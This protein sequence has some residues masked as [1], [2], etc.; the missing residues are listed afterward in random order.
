MNNKLF[1][2]Q[3]AA[4]I[5][6][7]STKTLRRWDKSGRFVP[8]RT[9][10]N[11]RRYAK[12]QIDGFVR[13]NSLSPKTNLP[14]VL[15]ELPSNTVFKNHFLLNS[16]VYPVMPKLLKSHEIMAESDQTASRELK[17]SSFK[18][19][20]ILVS[21]ILLT[22][23]TGLAVLAGYNLTPNFSEKK[24]Q[25]VKFISNLPPLRP[26][27]RD[28]GGQAQISLAPQNGGQAV[29]AAS[30][31]S[32]NL[33][34]NVNVPSV[35]SDTANFLTTIGIG[36]DTSDA[37]ALLD[38]T[39]EDKGFLAPR[40][41]TAQ[42]D[43]IASPATGLFVYN[44][45]TNQ[46]NMYDGTIWKNISG[47]A[48][49]DV[50]TGD[51][52][53]EAGAQGNSF[54]FHG[55][56]GGKTQVTAGNSSGSSNV[57]TFPDKTGT[58]ITTGNLSSITTT[59]TITSGVWNGTVI[60][61]AYGGTGADLSAGTQ[62][63]LPYFV[64][65][66]KLASLA[67]STS[68]YIFSTNG[69][70]AAPSWID[71]GTL[72]SSNFFE[73]VSGTLAP[74]I[75]TQDL[76]VGGQSTASAKFAFINVNNGMP[77][78]S[79]SG[80][81][82]LDSAGSIQ[83]TKNQTL[84]IGGNTTGNIILSPLNGSGNVRVNGTT[85]LNSLTYTWPSEGQSEGFSLITNGSGT[86]TWG[87][88]GTSI[89]NYWRQASGTTYTANS[90]VDVLIGGTASAS[91]KFA[92]LNV[93]SGTPT[94][95]ISAG[96]AGAAYLN[97]TGTLA[98]TAKQTLTLGDS[99]T[100]EILLAPGGTTA[101][102]GRGANLIAGG[103]LTGLTGLTSSGTITLTG[104]T[105]TASSLTSFTGG[106][107]AIDFAEFDVA[108]AT[109][110]I[111]I[112]DGGNLGNI[113]IE[114][115]ILDIDSL[116]F[117]GAGTLT[118]ADATGLILDSGDETITFAADNT[119]LTAAGLATITSAATLGISATALNLGAGSA[120][121]L[122]T[123]SDDN[124]TLTAHGT[125]D[126]LLLTDADTDL[127]LSAAGFADCGALTTVSNVVTCGSGGGSN[128]DVANGTIFPKIAS[129]DLLLGGTATSSAT[130]RVTGNSPF[131]GTNS[132]AS[133]AAKTSFAG[134]VVDN[135]IGDLFT[136]SSS[137][138]NRFVVKQSGNV[139]IGTTF[140]QYKL[141]IT[142]G[143][144]KTLNVASNSAFTVTQGGA[145]GKL[146]EFKTH[147]PGVNQ[148]TV[149][150]AY[151][152]LSTIIKPK[153]SLEFRLKSNVVWTA[154]TAWDTADTGTNAAPA[155]ADLD[156]DG[157]YDLLVGQSAGN[158]KAYQNTGSVTSPTWTANTAW[159]APDVGD[160][161]SPAF[162]DLDNDGDYDLL[163]GEY[164]LGSSTTLY[165]YE[166]TGSA[167]SPTWTA[168]T[169]WDISDIGGSLYSPAFADLDNDGDYDLLIGENAG[170]S[171]AYENTGS[172]SSPNWT[173][174]TAWNTPDVG[175]QSSPAFADLDNDGDYDLLMGESLGTTK[176]YENTGSVTSPVWIAK[177]A[178]D[179]TTD[180]GSFA[181]PA[182]A[183][184]DNDGDY[185]LLIGASG[186]VDWGYENTGS[187]V[188]SLVLGV[189]GR[190]GIGTNSALASL[191]VR[192]ISGT[193]P[194]ASFSA[195]TSFAGLLVD[196][197][198]VGDI[199][200]A[201]KSGATK[202]TVLNNGNISWA[203]TTN[204]LTTLASA[205]TAART[206]TFPDATGTIC[207]SSAN[208]AFDGFWN[209]ASGALYS[210]N[211]TMDLLI[212]GTGT[213]SAKFGFI[214]IAGGSPTATISGNLSLA[215][216]TT[217]GANTFNLLNNSTLNFQ[218]SPGGDAGLAT[219]LFL[220]NNGNVGI[221]TATPTT[222]LS[223]AGATSTI[224]NSSG[225]LTITP[226]SN[227]I[228]SSGS[229]GLG[230]T[231]PGL[232]L[233]VQDSQSAT[234]AAQIYNTN[235][236]TDADG[237]VIKL[238][239]TSTTAVA[240]TNHFA[241]FETFG[242]G[243]VGSVQGNG[244][245]G[246]TYATSGIADFAEYF[247][248]DASQQIP[249]GSVVCLKDNGLAVPC[250]PSAGS[251]Q[252][253]I[254]GVA[255]ER[256]AF[257][258]GEN[259]GDKSV[260]V[261]MVGQ[262]R[263]R[264]STANGEIKIGDPLTT[265][266]VSG[267]A[268]KATSVGQI[269]GK[270]LESFDDQGEGEILVSVNIT[271]YNPSIYVS[272]DGT[273]AGMADTVA[274]IGDQLTLQNQTL[275]L[276]GEALRSWQASQSA[277]LA[278][279]VNSVLQNDPLFRQSQDKITDLESRLNLL[280]QKVDQ[281]ASISAFLS[282]IINGQT[283]GASASAVLDLGLPAMLAQ[284]LQAGDVELNNATISGNLMVLGRTTVSDLGVTGNINAGLLAIH[285]LDGEINTLAGDL[286]LQKSGLGGLD[287]LDGKITIDASGNLTATGTITA[288]EIKANN[289]TV[290]GGESIGSA[291]IS[292]GL[293]FIEIVTPIASESSKI[294]L[295]A[296]SLTDRQLTVIEKSIGRFKVAI[297][298][299]TTAP[300]TF[301][302]WIVGNKN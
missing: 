222:K 96:T 15:N 7:V 114:G 228:I 88:L 209:S 99:N 287:I 65:T 196:N 176:A 262:V 243:I 98:T 19:G 169:A 260:A 34:L 285:G 146:A 160:E 175:A 127:K 167:S 237:L 47:G 73:Q 38:L 173:A 181:Q 3:E 72:P 183:D 234:A 159:N 155:F 50:S 299:P 252:G 172:A 97:A 178:W 180:L 119:T 101:L 9:V 254:I 67:P 236:G 283:L 16:K 17:A 46:Y 115:T 111:T 203:G 291:S 248:K 174:K 13:D 136:A 76:L 177:T 94:A 265:S 102:T 253:T 1:T 288:D 85:T 41:T 152:Q 108:A 289:Y 201:S 142:G 45:T 32:A 273:L 128:W 284:A 182:F 179:S 218:R 12:E 68:G 93:N 23:F 187:A 188:S 157:D 274:S 125:G 280:S 51:A 124:L 6:K 250:D 29:L 31:T 92:V 244:G 112:N 60:T 295:T 130:F 144:F 75:T 26:A 100:G 122:S 69:A 245:T 135:T 121:T 153:S 212:G 219:V 277:S 25:F 166:N 205:A 24:D 56:G 214:N 33:V 230:T 300:I 70:G 83:T 149:D 202:F 259:L 2:I 171:K 66:G 247:R 48:I 21:V 272:Y 278:E 104:E 270:A 161:A 266:S 264:V 87:D 199:F 8:I 246:V 58:F 39:S 81:I 54:Y 103:T 22:S 215:V 148:L 200:T 162:A 191:D 233:D 217:A 268:V 133:I 109:G 302:W 137:G 105:I 78:A 165:G 192:G 168:K 238:G 225:N 140:P 241:S 28:F 77:T 86:L 164:S 4:D 63:S 240:A 210:G 257:L 84:T 261:G 36:A 5:L 242:I 126:L 14:H 107:T 269:L 118:T 221:G 276:Q 296:T 145:G 275:A 293:T 123:V 213:A 150:Y 281:Q 62:G 52:F 154:N 59:G 207:L 11:Q 139:G 55:T 226:A 235:S 231:T 256:P 79:I 147:L 91:A 42:R 156:N 193:I 195:V 131:A 37:S 190:V 40:M 116:D 189:N 129:Q 134:L 110:S 227:L 216:P 249:Y 30:T 220:A 255:S 301:D 82:V 229:V 292:A 18:I 138:L 198:G 132:V 294:F 106:A 95:S 27:Q 263:T 286:Y 297:P 271:W 113:S 44:T 232:K 49:G 71:P 170:V 151:N 208:C 197:S 10:G 206:I 61:S 89:S 141:D 184:L 120:A 239:N 223:V 290:L 267:I 143:N 194:I 90:T 158:S 117:V 185:D 298:S 282:D 43:A 258:G 279:Q 35:F 204:F 211:T 224:S 64:S 57:L 251:G 163:I 53:T 80:N 74:K 20:V 186:G